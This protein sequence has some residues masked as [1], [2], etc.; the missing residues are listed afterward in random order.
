MA[1]DWNA[2]AADVAAGIAEAGQ[3]GLI[4]RQLPSPS[5]PSDWPQLPAPDPIN[6]PCTLIV[7]EYSLHERESSLIGA[8]DKKV[9]VA[10]PVTLAAFADNPASLN[11]P[12]PADQ[13]VIQGRA[14]AIVDVRPVSPAGVPV[15]W[16]LQVT[17]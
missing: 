13:V 17:F 16:E 5:G 6:A 10:V 12:T 11:A 4:R 1:E 8:S 3:P 14:H 9:L 15:M 2:V 7:V